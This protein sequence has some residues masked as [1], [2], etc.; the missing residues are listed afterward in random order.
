MV[1]AREP[2]RKSPT[3]FIGN[4]GRSLHVTHSPPI[5]GHRTPCPLLSGSAGPSSTSSWVTLQGF[6]EASPAFLL[7]VYLSIL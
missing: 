2:S 3:A 4:R 5:C 6:L 7:S 1:A